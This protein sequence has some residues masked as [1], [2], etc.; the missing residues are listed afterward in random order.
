MHLLWRFER[1]T[2]NTLKNRNIDSQFFDKIEMLINDRTKRQLFFW[3]SKRIT[4]ASVHMFSSN[5][6]ADAQQCVL[7]S[8]RTKQKKNCSQQSIAF[9]VVRYFDNILFF[10]CSYFF[11][12]VLSS[13]L[14]LFSRAVRKSC[15]SLLSNAVRCVLVSLVDIQT[16]VFFFCMC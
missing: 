4:R 2:L 7:L 12:L 5:T 3:V 6:H 15:F 11:P 9:A 1:I 10:L 13:C 14:H 8:E 16:S